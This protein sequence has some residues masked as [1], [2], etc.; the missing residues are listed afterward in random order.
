MKHV[1]ECTGY[2]MLLQDIVR[3][4]GISLYDSKGKKYIDFEAG[5]WCTALG[6]NHPRINEAMKKQI[7][8][9]IHCGFMSSSQVVEEAAKDVLSTLEDFDG[10]CLFLSSGSEAVEFSIKISKA[11]MG[12]KKLL[13][14]NESYLSAY[15]TSGSNKDAEWVKFSL[16]ECSNCSHKNNC[17]EC[18]Q[19]NSLDFE[20]IGIFVFEPGN[21]G[22]TVKLPPKNLVNEITNRI[23]RNN[24][25]IIVDEVTTGIGRTGKWYGFQHYQIKPDIIAMGKGIGNGYPVSVVVVEEQIVRKMEDQNI[26]HSQSHQNDALGCAVIS[27]VIK[28]I[29]E[30][31]LI[32]RSN[33]TGQYFIEELIKLM[34]SVK[35]RIK[36]VRGIGLMIAVEFRK[37]EQLLMEATFQHLFKEGFIIGYKPALNLIRFYPPL[38]ITREDINL[39]MDALRET[40]Y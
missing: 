10:K 39:L 1:V 35:G 14:F 8:K 9:I 20:N 25:L 37:E 33:D 6:H 29:N 22:G 34:D 5:V 36:E 18:E 21:S 13:T 26:R 38:T 28:T 40:F 19:L 3:A 27:E 16:A 24:G 17:Q 2:E 12:D 30:S 4:D 15:G 31:N 11:V 7:D 23:K 32:T